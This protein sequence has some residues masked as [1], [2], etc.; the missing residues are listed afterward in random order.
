MLGATMNK[1]SK[2][3]ILLSLVI[4]FPIYA[5]PLPSIKKAVKSSGMVFV[6]GVGSGSGFAVYQQGD[7]TLI[8]TNDHVCQMTRGVSSLSQEIDYSSKINTL[9]V[10]VLDSNDKV[11]KGRVVKTAN[12][13]LLK[14]GKKGSDLCLLSVEGTFTLAAFSKEDDMEVGNKIF[15]V[16]APHGIYPMVHEGYVGPVYN[17]DNDDDSNKK[18]VRITTLLVWPGS[19]GSAVYDFDTGLVVG[20]VYAILPVS[21]KVEVPVMSVMV[22]GNQARDFLNTYLEAK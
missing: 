8:M 6:K 21:K 13:H 18:E 17:S 9:E 2:L 1:I 10:E 12:L 4:S 20:V 16:G 11:H 22:P 3:L 14:R 15:S 5:K 7:R 19:S